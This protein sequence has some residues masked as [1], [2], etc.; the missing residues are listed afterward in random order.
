VTAA[1][2]LGAFVRRQATVARPLL[3]LQIFRSRAVSGANGTQV[4]MVASALG[5]QFL[6]AMFLQQ[7]LGYGPAR[8]GLAVVPVAVGI[9]IL[10]L[11]PSGRLAAR[12]GARPVLLAGLALLVAGMLLLAR[13]PADA[14][15][16]VDLLPALLLL[17]AG[18]GLAL[19]TVTAVAMA[20]A[21]EA[22]AGLASGLANTAQQVGGALGVSV[23]AAVAAAATDGPGTDARA[24]GYR[25]A[26]A[27][28]AGLAAGAL[29][30]AA[31][32]LR[33]PTPAGA[34]QGP[35]RAQPVA[36]G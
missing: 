30:V 36:G 9:G 4:L 16:A 7:V 28:A 2:L 31:L 32:V 24:A 13:L 1:A 14:A 21:T 6:S 33:G 29:A 17:G 15:Y 11:G 25:V 23:L 18:A 34:E 22:D 20:D 27:V 5:F 3:P 35:G 10:S 26:F 12:V 8:T 19:P